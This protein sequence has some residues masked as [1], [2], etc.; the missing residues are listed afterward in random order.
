VTHT[1]KTERQKDKNGE[2]TTGSKAKKIDLL[3]RNENQTVGPTWLSPQ[4]ADVSTSTNIEIRR[5]SVGKSNRCGNN[6]H[7]VGNE[8]KRERRTEGL[9]KNVLRLNTRHRDTRLCR[10]KEL[11]DR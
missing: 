2:E 1:E 3:L 8:L 7:R 6:T 10:R 4:E 9:N 11:T 5:K